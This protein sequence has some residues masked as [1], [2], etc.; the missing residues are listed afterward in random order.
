MFDGKRA[1]QVAAE[2]DMPLSSVYV[3]RSRVLS[4]LRREAAGL[5]DSP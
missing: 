2:L 5:I 3:A 1:D 4:A